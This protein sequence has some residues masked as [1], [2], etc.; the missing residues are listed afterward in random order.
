MD[1]SAVNGNVNEYLVE[2]TLYQG[3]LDMLLQLIEREE[4]DITKISLVKVTTPFLEYARQLNSRHAEEVSSFLVMASRLM[5][6]KSEALLPRPPEREPGEEDPG[7]EL[8]S[9]L[10]LYKRY[11]EIAN[12]LSIQVDR[13]SRTYLRLVPPPKIEPQLDLSGLSIDDLI[14]AANTIFELASQESPSLDYVMTGPKITIRD[15]ISF[16]T[17]TILSIPNSTFSKLI[18]KNS[19][20]NEIV[21]TFLALLELIKQYRVHADQETLF[22][23]IQIERANNWNDTSKFDLDF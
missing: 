17:K 6:I 18:A 20:R 15:K 8:L 23:E 9:Q 14:A 16:I 22:G 5:Q 10:L 19:S 11:K 2:T 3:P 4:L 7:E 1:L 21:I 13:D 12:Y